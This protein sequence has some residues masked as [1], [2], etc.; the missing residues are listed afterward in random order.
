MPLPVSYCGHVPEAKS[1]SAMRRGDAVKR[2]CVRCM[3]IGED[4]ISGKMA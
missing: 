1:I 3:V 4:V 2:L